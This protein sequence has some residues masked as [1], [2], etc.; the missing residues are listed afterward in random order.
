MKTYLIS[1]YPLKI[2]SNFIFIHLNEIL[3]DTVV[4]GQ[5]GAHQMSSVQEL[6]KGGGVIMGLEEEH[7]EKRPIIQPAEVTHQLISVSG[8]YIYHS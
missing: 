2:F 3:G 6:G 5:S 1:F 7:N 8:W 4:L